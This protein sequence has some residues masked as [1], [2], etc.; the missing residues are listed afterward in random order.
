MRISSVSTSSTCTT[1]CGARLAPA[2][3]ACSAHTA[4]L[5]PHLAGNLVSAAADIRKAERGS[6]LAFSR[7]RLEPDA[8]R[9]QSAG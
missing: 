7:Q 3:H 2:A 9:V 6:A 4:P 5:S 1:D 8:S